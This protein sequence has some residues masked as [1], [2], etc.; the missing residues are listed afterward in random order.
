MGR[1]KKSKGK[2]KVDAS[3]ENLKEW[4]DGHAINLSFQQRTALPIKELVNLPLVTSLDFSSNRLSSLG[5]GF[6]ALA[7]LVRIDLS[8][9]EL[10]EL[11]QE[12]CEMDDLRHLNLL[13]NKLVKFPYQFAKLKLKSL[14][15]AKNPIDEEFLP[16]HIIGACTTDDE[17][18]KCARQVQAFLNETLVKIEK[19]AARLAKKADKK[20]IRVA[21]RAAEA[22]ELARAERKKV[23]AAERAKKQAEYAAKQEAE[24]GGAGAGADGGD[25]ADDVDAVAV[26]GS[27]GCPMIRYFIMLIAFINLCLVAAIKLEIISAEDVAEQ[28]AQLGIKDLLPVTKF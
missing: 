1:A 19:E 15:L 20:V 25:A 17:R 21:R 24:A 6:G 3:L 16:R 23:K 11:P 5:D 28:L 4:I 18:R 2:D 22:E 7:N 27:T 13:G 14:S 10:T 26:S 8:N 12:L 9:N